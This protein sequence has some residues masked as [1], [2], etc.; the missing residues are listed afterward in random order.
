M[1][2]A[3]FSESRV[4]LSAMLMVVSLIPSLALARQPEPEA[5]SLVD[6]VTVVAADLTQPRGFL[7]GSNGQLV[8]ALAGS[9]GP[10]RGS[11]LLPDSPLMGGPTASV[12]LAD[13]GCVTELATE[14][15]SSTSPLGRTWG[16][17]DLAVVDTQLY[18]LVAGGGAAYGN[19]DE[20][21]GVYQVQSNGAV[22]LVADLSEWQ[23]A[24]PVAVPPPLDRV[25]DGMPFSMANIDGELWVT[26]R[27]HGQLLRVSLDGTVSRIVDFSS[28]GLVPTGITPSP[29]G[30][31]YVAI[32]GAPPYP[33]GA[34]KILSVTPDGTVSDAWT[35]LT[36]A[37]AVAVAP[38]GTLFALEAGAPQ[39]AVPPYL[40]PHSGR[41]VRQ[42]GPDTSAL[43]V[44]E[45]DGP[46]AL[47][48]G[49]DGGIYVSLSPSGQ[50]NIAGAIIEIDAALE[51]AVTIPAGPWQGPPCVAVD[52]SSAT[53]T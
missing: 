14:L 47:E 32:V 26:E 45:L 11:G 23:R 38:G 49:G 8:I 3:R 52:E 18:A 43:V 44:S 39:S 9:G 37:V 20:P 30:G 1:S 19:R 31:A 50:S 15:P 16:V 21:N 36:A 7:V 48:I 29:L 22:T 51:N 6:G 41:V 27:N 34:S 33:A 25:P 2:V 12:V 13:A 40:A 17:T 24:N 53:P 28:S 35:G 42:T 5:L 46:S 4:V 10:N